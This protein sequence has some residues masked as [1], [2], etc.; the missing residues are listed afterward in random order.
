MPPGPERDD[1]LRFMT[2]PRG[3]PGEKM[4]VPHSH[5]H[6]K[7]PHQTLFSA[8]V[9]S[10]KIAAIPGQLRAPGVQK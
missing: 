3:S 8:P 5:D 9:G 10:D 1:K 6:D 4:Y 2:E 7:V